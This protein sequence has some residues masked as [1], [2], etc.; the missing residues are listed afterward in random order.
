MKKTLALLLALITVFATVSLAS[1]S[2]KQEEGEGADIPEFTFD[3]PGTATGDETGEKTTDASGNVVDSNDFVVASGTAYILH[4]VKVRKDAKNNSSTVGVAAWGSSVTLQER[5]A[6]W[7]KITFTDNGIQLEGYVRNELLTTDATAITRVD[8]EA[9]VA[10]KISGLGK[11]QDGTPY[12]LK[13]RTTPWNCTTSE[14]YT[15][16]NVLENISNKKYDVKD[17]DLV[18]KIGATQDGK[19]TYIR[20]TKIVDGVETVEWGWC[21]SQFITVE[22]ENNDPITDPN[23]PP[24][25]E[26]IL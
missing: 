15:D 24:A 9:P 4:P 8:L 18:E 12:T 7:S 21:A 26:P 16:V 14:E 5:N 23:T 10:A 25:V 22:G 1:C 11:K 17:G 6:T 19:W 13:V 3:I 2:K 20:F